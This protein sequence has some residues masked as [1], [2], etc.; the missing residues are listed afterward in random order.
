MH[1]MYATWSHHHNQ[2][3]ERICHS[4]K[5]PHS[6]AIMKMHTDGPLTPMIQ[7]MIFSTL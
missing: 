4:P 6:I 5:L 2:D 7:L 1:S 3:N